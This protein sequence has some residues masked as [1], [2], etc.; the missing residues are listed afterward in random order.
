MPSYTYKCDT[1]GT[2]SDIAH[3]VSEIGPRLCTESECSGTM[4]VDITANRSYL[5][6]AAVPTRSGL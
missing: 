3:Q 5:T 1:C 4:T 2:K 6:K